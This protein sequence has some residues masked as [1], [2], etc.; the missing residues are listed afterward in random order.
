MSEERPIPYLV[1]TIPGKTVGK[2]RTRS[3]EHSTKH[4]TPKK[5]RVYENYV[6][7]M[8]RLALQKMPFE[9][10]KAFPTDEQVFLDLEI[11]HRNGRKPDADNVVK[12]IEDGLTKI[13]WDD[14][15]NVLP[16]VQFETW[17][18]ANPRVE[19]RITPTGHS[20]GERK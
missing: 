7:Y 15:R 19:A 1:F 13:L 14:D 2:Q 18:D 9:L 8:A 11:Y 20:P 10:A 12:V 5:T 16:R 3:A 17:P 4:V 6:G